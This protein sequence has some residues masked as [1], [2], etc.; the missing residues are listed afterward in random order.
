MC[1]FSQLRPQTRQEHRL[2]IASATS[3]GPLTRKYE[4]N[5]FQLHNGDVMLLIKG[6]EAGEI[7][8]AIKQLRSQFGDEP[9][10][11]RPDGEPDAFIARYRLE[12]TMTG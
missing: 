3:F 12:R 5:L 8:A 7:D 6:A 4:S 10:V 1:G 2:R 11:D 9:C